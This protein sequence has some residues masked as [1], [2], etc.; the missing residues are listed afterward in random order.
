DYDRGNSTIYDA[1]E[2]DQLDLS[3]LLSAV[4]N[5]GAGQSIGSLV[6]V[7][8][9]ADAATAAL[10]VD[11]DGAGGGARWVTIAE[12]NGIHLGNTVNVILDASQPAGTTLTLQGNYGLNGDFTG[13]GNA[14]LL[15]RND[16]GAL[17]LWQMNGTQL[18][19]SVSL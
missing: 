7:V 2:E 13:D 17:L 3:A 19:S 10:Q 15:W 18:Q 11:V 9:G 5:H 14:D 8:D 12:L 16:N 1:A 4:Y 6:R